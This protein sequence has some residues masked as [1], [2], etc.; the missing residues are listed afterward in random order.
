M[1]LFFSTPAFSYKYDLSIAA[2][3][4]NE[5]R[6]MKEWI[7][8]HMRVGVEHFWL[9]N[10]NSEDDYLSILEPYIKNGTVELFEW[11]SVQQKN[12]WDH[13]CFDVQ[14][15]AY[16]DALDRARKKSKWLA[17]IDLDEYIVPVCE[18]SIPEVLE[19]HFSFVSG[20]CVNWQFYG[21]SHVWKVPKGKMLQNLTWKLQWDHPDNRL[22]KSIVK[23]SEVKYCPNPHC[24]VYNSGHWHVNPILERVSGE[25][26]G[27]Y[28][29][30]IRIN[31]YWARDEYNLNE[32]KIPRYKKWGINPDN[33]RNRAN[34]MNQEFDDCILKFL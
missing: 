3:F 30:K 20:L 4:Q 26:T 6:F 29:D 23:P 5:G 9:Y 31:H 13:H 27:V 11:P 19:K 14:I 25:N 32:I 8:Y 15:R 34:G 22:F 10:N 24:C 12:D 16:N 21:T 17:L 2:I 1:F 28:I 7:D 18:E 33:I